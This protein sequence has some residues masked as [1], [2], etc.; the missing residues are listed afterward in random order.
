MRASQK[1]IPGYMNLIITRKAC[2]QSSP[3]H[4]ELNS[5]TEDNKTYFAE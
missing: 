3:C 2:S 1:D 5:K 4:D